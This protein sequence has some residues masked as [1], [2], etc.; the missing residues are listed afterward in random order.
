MKILAIRGCNLASLAGEFEIDL[1]RAPLGG[2]GVFAIVGNTGAGK[3]TLLDA[4]CVALF[5]RTPRLTNHSTVKVGRGIDERALLGAQ[6]VRT[7]LRRGTAQGWAEVDFESGDARQYRARWSVRRARGQSDGTL[8]DEQLSL[9]AIEGGE[10]FG[11]TKTETL[12]A[13]HARLGLSFDQFRRSALL[14]QGE[15]A[16]FLRADGKDRSELLERMTGTQIYSRLSVAAHVKAALADQR[17][18]DGRAAA[19]AIAVLDDEAERATRAEL[20][21]ATAAAQAARRRHAQAIEAARWI[22]EAARRASALA[23]AGAEHAAARAA[24]VGA[25]ADR[26]EL[27]LR[28]RAELL[29]PAWEESARLE[30]GVAVAT[31]DAAAAGAAAARAAG[32]LA[33]I[34]DRRAQIAAIQAP[35]RAARIAAGIVERGELA[36]VAGDDVA[37]LAGGAIA[38][39]AGPGRAERTSG[40]EPRAESRIASGAESRIES[41]AESRAES[42]IASGAESGIASGAES[43]IE[44][45]AESGIAS[46]VESRAG[47]RIKSFVRATADDAA[48]LVARGALAPEIAGWPELD[49]R[50]T[51]DLALADAIAALDRALTEHV[52]SKAKLDRS[53]KVV[54]GEVRA[55]VHK[56]DEAKRKAAGYSQKRG[57]TLDAARRLED[58]ARTRLGEVERLVAIAA[59]ARAAIQARDDLDHELTQLAAA[60]AGDAARQTALAEAQRFAHA[61][62]AEQARVV[63]D[64]RRAAGYEHARAELSDGEPCPLCGAAEHPWRDRGAL[65][66]VIAAAGARLAATQAELDAIATEV[67]AIAARHHEHT[68][69]RARLVA[70][71]TAVVGEAASAITAW[72]DQLGALG[73]LLLAG[74]PATP[75]AEALAADRQALAKKALEDARA[76]RSQTEAATKAAQDAQAEVQLGQ[77]AVD[78]LAA[79]LGELDRRI[80]E[81]DATLGRTRGEHASKLEQRA[82]LTGELAA[83]IVR[84]TTALPASADAGPAS[85]A[86][87]GTDAPT[88]TSGRAGSRTSDAATVTAVDELGARRVARGA[89]SA[90]ARRASTAS[91]EATGRNASGA[92]EANVASAAIDPARVVALVERLQASAPMRPARAPLPSSPLAIVRLAMAAVVAVWR[93]RAERTAHADAALSAAAVAIEREAREI[94]RAAAEHTARRGEAERRRD[95]GGRELAAAAGRLAAARGDA[96]FEAEELR[97][98]LSADPSRVDALAERLAALERGADR[99]RAV[100]TE[101]ERQV[102]EHAARRPVADLDTGPSVDAGDG[103]TDATSLSVAGGAGADRGASMD[104]EQSAEPQRSLAAATRRAA[105][106]AAAQ[107]ADAANVEA[108]AAAVAA[109]DQ[110][111]AQLAAALAADASARTRRATALA[112]VAADEASAEVDRILGDVI[113]SHDG[114]LFRSFAQSLTLDSLLAVANAHLEEL[115]PRYQLERVPRHDL[116]LQVIDRDLGSEIRS[117]Q[118]LSGGES[119]LVSL[120]LALGLSSMSAHDVR[121]RT[122]LID[123]GFGTLDPATLDSALSVLDA[124][125]ATG[126]QVGVIS[127]VPALVERVGAHVR[128]VQRGGGRSEVIVA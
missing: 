108:L 46:G 18:R 88:G 1:V 117:V 3:S 120:A 123:E 68:R 106:L 66:D 104:D 36:R 67:A 19:L 42:G 9:T 58:Q 57:L 85:P 40:I 25:E 114:K 49:H 24:L 27:G 87:A 89:A 94:E 61:M 80:A 59:A 101:R 33:T 4:M 95:E 79:K 60:V 112:D 76:T 43:G 39:A 119:F 107:A 29:R 15:F 26:A 74:D 50:F 93:E 31:A 69:G 16:A 86:M 28:R 38:P 98:L 97:R 100:V 41:R 113:G 128:I 53:H 20:E 65:D 91:G 84:W 8:Q 56:H 115:A 116:E 51:Q 77:V 110:R 78:Q 92:L 11:G 7:L 30:R 63:D 90:G 64:L 118:S 71:R 23:E 73:E 96:G 45:G 21:V 22:A 62:R 125:Q 2:A 44:S 34:A 55:A 48:W 103:A 32:E 13:I 122:L 10:R 14:A 75:A 109:A 83:A 70:Q 111:A 72:R 35:V 6:D 102:A 126:R 121:V 17:L 54:A 47:S 105:L 12:K 52:D 127:H 124:L 99:T 82:A 37:W 81:L 5:D